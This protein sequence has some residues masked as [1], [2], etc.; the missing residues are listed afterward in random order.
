MDQGVHAPDLP[1]TSPHSPATGG[2]AAAVTAAP[3]P[4]GHRNRTSHHVRARTA[5]KPRS[6]QGEPPGPRRR[7]IAPRL[8]WRL[9]GPT[10]V[11]TVQLGLSTRPHAPK[12]GAPGEARAVFVRVRVH[13]GAHRC[14]RPRGCGRAM[15]DPWCAL[16]RNNVPIAQPL[17]TGTRPAQRAGRLAA[18]AD[19]TV[20]AGRSGARPTCPLRSAGATRQITQ[21]DHP[22]MEIAKLSTGGRLMMRVEKMPTRA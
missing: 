21:P 1:D 20:A 17:Q 13:G 18:T 3:R 15:R 22:T 9:L 10:I 14:V 7:P 6:L 11:E 4:H 8:L 2:E 19:P 16:R 5:R 12:T